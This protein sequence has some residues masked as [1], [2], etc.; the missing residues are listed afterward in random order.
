MT[1]IVIADSVENV[2]ADT[3]ETIYTSPSGGSGTIITAWAA[4]N[5]SGVNASYKAY[6]Y[7]SSGTAVSPIVPLKIVVR[8]KFDLAPTAVNQLIPNGGSLRVE[9]SAAGSITFRISGVQL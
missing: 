4:I 5:N 6:I 8:D 2:D 7:N 9:S 1:D 3:I